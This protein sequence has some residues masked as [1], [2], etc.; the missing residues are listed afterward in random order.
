MKD[1]EV[2]DDFIKALAYNT[3]KE[4]PDAEVQEG[5]YRC[6]MCGRIFAFSDVWTDDE[7]RDEA[8]RKGI[9]LTESVIVCNDCY[10]LTPWGQT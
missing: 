10:K 6:A 4:C 2:P 7:A 8:E 5:E 3:A 9:D 1:S